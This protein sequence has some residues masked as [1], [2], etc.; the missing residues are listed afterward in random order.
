MNANLGRALFAAGFT[1]VLAVM[2][3]DER[4]NSRWHKLFPFNPGAHENAHPGAMSAPQIRERWG[5][6]QKL[7]A[8]TGGE[9]ATI[10]E[11]TPDVLAALGLPPG[12]I[13]TALDLADAGK[14]TRN[15][16]QWACDDPSCPIGMAPIVE[17]PEPQPEPTPSPTPTP[18]PTPTPLPVP[19]PVEIPADIA[20]AFD[21]IEASNVKIQDFNGV[22]WG[23]GQVGGAKRFGRSTVSTIARVR[24]WLKTLKVVP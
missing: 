22:T 7:V 10:K 2:H 15:G 5:Y 19:R 9:G 17:P 16:T 23:P 12:Y 3:P 8:G 11:P 14:L 6:D 18:T 4:H 13:W 21:Q 20:R 24:T 1:Q